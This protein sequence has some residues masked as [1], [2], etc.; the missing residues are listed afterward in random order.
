MATDL[1]QF[2]GAALPAHLSKFF[3][4]VGSNIEDRQTVP[5]LSYEGK[6]WQISL[7]GQKTKLMAKPNEDGDVLPLGVMRVVVLDYAK[8]R[9]RAY[10][11][12]AYDPAKPGKPV[13]WSDDGVAPDS[14]LPDTL[15]AGAEANTPHKISLKCESCPMSAKGSKVTD[16]GK[17]V[18][19]CA[20]HRMLAVVP[21]NRLDFEPL[22]LKIA[23]T[24]DWDKQ[25][26]ELEQAGWRAF[27]NYADYL[28]SMGIPHTAAVETRIK[29]DPSAAYPKLI[30]NAARPLE[31]AE[32]AQIIPT[33]Q[34]Q[35][36]K[37]LL[38]GKWTP[39]GPDGEDKTAAAS[40]TTAP[41]P[42]PAP[43]PAPAPAATP[44]PQ[45][46]SEQ[47]LQQAAAA[48][49]E[50]AAAPAA[51]AAEK[52]KRTRTP[53]A[54]DP[55]V[56]AATPP[57]PGTPEYVAWLQAQLAQAQAAQ[58][59]PAEPAPAPAA[60]GVPVMVMD[61]DDDAMPDLPGTPAATPAAAAPAATTTP[62][63]AATAAVPADVAGLLDAWGDDD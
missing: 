35:K 23:M 59:A 41:D 32:I 20:Q 39:T 4:E 1:T 52:P 19:A 34:S 31:E 45:P 53:K 46:E 44:A 17:A 48:K 30:F 42:A 58:A 10:Y 3:G 29:F 9:G 50:P 60:G 43:E 36:V 56:A 21:S 40:T 11:E 33:V 54:A 27:Q 28:K 47:L 63:P 15:P 51:P 5:S 62:A 7:D 6:V 12:G 25:S 18:T 13:C 14:S 37:D 49:V 57:A 55:V 38:A 8:R 16:N 61:E 24:S 22:R 26:P 2:T